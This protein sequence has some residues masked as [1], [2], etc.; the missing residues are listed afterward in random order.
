[1]VKVSS[2]HYEAS[3]RRV[4]CQGFLQAVNILGTVLIWAV[5]PASPRDPAKPTPGSARR[6]TPTYRATDDPRDLYHNVLVALDAVRD[7]NNG[8]PS[9]LAV[10]IN[11]L[12]LEEGDRA[13]GWT[14]L[15]GR[16]SVARWG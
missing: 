6:V 12:D 1:M 16:P 11:A 15:A 8:Q 13:T 4:A 3:M 2:L 7:I 9:A 10:W 5:T 14:L